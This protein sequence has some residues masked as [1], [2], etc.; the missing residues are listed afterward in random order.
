MTSGFTVDTS[1]RPWKEP[2]PHQPTTSCSNAFGKRPRR[3]IARPVRPSHPLPWKSW[4]AM[5]YILQT[6]GD[7][8][9]PTAVQVGGASGVTE[10]LCVM[11][12]IRPGV[13][14]PGCDTGCS[15]TPRPCYWFLGHRGSSRRTRWPP[16]AALAPPTLGDPA[17]DATNWRAEH[18]IR[19]AVVTRK[20]CGGNR[21]VRGAATQRSSRRC[22]APSISAASTLP[23]SSRPYCRRGAPSSRRHCRRHRR[24]LTR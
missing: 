10:T 6:V 7:L 15:V 17:I 18:A 12:A 1:L 24:R 4:P 8:G 3:I 9:V 14:G 16:H 20:V 13:G 19:P 23:T 11:A 22:C 21:T 2:R 5:R